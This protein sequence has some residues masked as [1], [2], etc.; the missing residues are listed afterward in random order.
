MEFGIANAA[1]T[2]PKEESDAMMVL[3]TIAQVLQEGQHKQ[4]QELMAHF[5]AALKDLPGS[6]APAPTPQ[7][8]PARVQMYPICPHCQ[9]R[10]LKPKSC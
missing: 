4:M 2:A 1:V 8:K 3:A 10:H 6:A 5:T 9:K 7:P